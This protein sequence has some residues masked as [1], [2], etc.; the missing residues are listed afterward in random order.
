MPTILQLRR[1]TDSQNNGFI[2]AAGELTF[3][4]T[5]ST[6]RAH[7]GSTQGGH[8]L[9]TFSEVSGAGFDSADVLG[10][11]DSAY[12]QSRQNDIFR[13]SGFVT[14]IIDEVY[15]QARDRIR[16][17]GFVTGI[18]DSAHVQAR[19]KTLSESDGTLVISGNIIPDT[20]STYSL[21]TADHKFKDL[22]LSG[23]TIFIDQLALSADPETNT[24]SLS[25]LDS[26]ALTKLG[27]LATVDSSQVGQIV[28]SA[29]IQDKI[30]EP[31]LASIIDS[32]YVLARSTN[33]IQSQIDNLIDAAPGALDTLNEL[34]AAINDDSNF[35]GTITTSIATK[36]AI[37][38]FGTYFDSN[39]DAAVLDGIGLAY[40]SVSN[41]LSIDSSELASYFST[42]NI[43]E[44][45]NLYYT[46]TRFDSDFSDNT[47]SDLTEGDNQYYTRARVDSAFNDRITNIDRSVIPDS[48]VAYDLGSP[49]RRFRDLY[50]SGNSLIIGDLAISDAGDG[51]GLSIGEVDSVGEIQAGTG[52]TISSK[53][54]DNVFDVRLDSTGQQVVDTFSI[55]KFRT[56]RYII[57]MA[58]DSIGKYHST[59]I[60]L[61]HNDVDIFMT[62][63]AILKTQDSDVGS[64]TANIS[65]SSVQLLI[66]PEFQ[67]ITIKAKRLSIDV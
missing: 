13:D 11:V 49:T 52:G 39:L 9:A 38:D 4:T 67:N 24:I 16:D 45:D 35:V 46:T 21:G 10:I 25:R 65:D 54:I 27:V 48:D 66:T 51:G 56:A 14:G 44:G 22:F 55:N 57:Q 47:T 40:N 42:D 12:I 34:A 15:I 6:I 5:N 64:I 33:Y 8:R 30:D 36:L 63:Y 53:N 17:S 59:E 2:G 7:D 23:G 20:D 50:L 19:F 31:F 43:T 62:E 3:D 29:Y 28:D 41:T 61:M 26:G 37:S 58:Q 1:G 32:D 60:L 18:I